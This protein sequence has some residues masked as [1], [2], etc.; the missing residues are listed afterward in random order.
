M[1][2]SSGKGVAVLTTRRFALSRGELGTTAVAV[3]V[4]TTGYLLGGGTYLA[5]GVVG[6]LVGLG[7]LAAS[8]PAR[9]DGGPPSRSGSGPASCFAAA[10]AT[11][12][13][14]RAG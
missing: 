9:A 3:V 8:G 10:R 7:L 1:W 11:D 4:S 12:P 14:P 2:C 13:D 5:R 6:D